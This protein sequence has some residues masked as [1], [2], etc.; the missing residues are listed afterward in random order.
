[1]ARQKTQHTSYDDRG[2]PHGVSL[3]AVASTF[4]VRGQA[5]TQVMGKRSR[6]KIVDVAGAD[7]AVLDR[8]LAQPQ[9]RK[10]M[11]VTD[12]R[13]GSEVFRRRGR[14]GRSRATLSN[15]ADA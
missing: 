3:A 15:K 2:S 8:L 11:I 5:V 6:T 13:A 14:S 7:P 12:L 1:V 10:A 4:G 9:L